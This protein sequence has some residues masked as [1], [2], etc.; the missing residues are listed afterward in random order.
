MARSEPD[1]NK[2][3]LVQTSRNAPISLTSHAIKHHLAFRHLPTFGDERDREIRLCGQVEVE[4]E[5]SWRGLK[6]A[7]ESGDVKTAVKLMLLMRHVTQDH[8]LELLNE[9]LNSAALYDHA[10]VVRELLKAGADPSRRF[11]GEPALVVAAKK[12]RVKPLMLMLGENDEDEAV[13]Q[14]PADVNCQDYNGHTA[15]M[16]AVINVHHDVVG[17]LIQA[18]A[19]VN[20]RERHAGMTALMM[21]SE[22]GSAS[23]VE[24][25]LL[26]GAKQDLQ[27]KHC[28]YS[29]LMFAAMNGH[30]EV[31]Q[32]LLQFGA[33]MTITDKKGL[34]AVHLASHSH[35]LKV[36]QFLSRDDLGLMQY[37]PQEVLGA[38]TQDG[39]TALMIAVRRGYS[40]I[41]KFLVMDAAVDA[42]AANDDGNT[43]LSLAVEYSRHDLVILL[44]ERGGGDMN[45]ENSAG[46]SPLQLAASLRLPAMRELLRKGARLREIYEVEQEKLRLQEEKLR[47]K[48]EQAGSDSEFEISSSSDD[49]EDEEEGEEEE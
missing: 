28:G 11:N 4:I 22:R 30:R 34:M 42:R 23:L 2:D 25:L 38:R 45:Y 3:G 24:V 26:S 16:E 36:L 46:M 18:G 6:E 15:L 20:K 47:L 7:A 35:Q 49:E 5:D 1:L 32:L 13:T 19:D 37:D 9:P 39:C 43:A 31:I 40:D 33:S 10:P 21:A 41:V 14:T 8:Y 48:R 44:M 12:G 27:E 17:I 29:A